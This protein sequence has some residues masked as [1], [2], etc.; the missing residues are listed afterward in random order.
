MKIEQMLI[1]SCSFL[2]EDVSTELVARVSGVYQ[3]TLAR[4]PLGSW[5]R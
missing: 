3:M 2:T 1:C 4:T 5:D